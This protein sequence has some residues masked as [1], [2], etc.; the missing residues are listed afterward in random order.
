MSIWQRCINSEGS[1][2]LYSKWG[3]TGSFSHLPVNYISHK[4]NQFWL[5]FPSTWQLLHNSLT[6][7]GLFPIRKDPDKPLLSGASLPAAWI[8]KEKQC[9]YLSLTTGWMLGVSLPVCPGAWSFFTLTAVDCGRWLL[10]VVVVVVVS[11][12]SEGNRND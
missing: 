12:Q 5:L 1:L 3:L 7:S 9:L 10:C 2:A 8:V 11:F 4:N 6:Q